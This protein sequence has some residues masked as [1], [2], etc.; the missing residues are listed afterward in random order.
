[1]LRY[2]VEITHIFVA[3]IAAKDRDNWFAR[4]ASLWE[5]LYGKPLPQC[6]K[7]SPKVALPQATRPGT[8]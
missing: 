1:M 7:L 8:T 4:P 6:P 5:W 3:G 2:P